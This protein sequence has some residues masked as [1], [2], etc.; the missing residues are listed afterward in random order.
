MW[1]KILNVPIREIEVHVITYE[2]NR[3]LTKKPC[4]L[5]IVVTSCPHHIAQIKESERELQSFLPVP[6]EI[7]KELYIAVNIYPYMY[8]VYTFRTLHKYDKI[9]IVYQ[10]KIED[11]FC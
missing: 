6:S 3:T 4:L 9:K 11:I 10:Y 8:V 1:C 7:C 5:T 2:E